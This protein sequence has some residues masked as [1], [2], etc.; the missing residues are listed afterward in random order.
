MLCDGVPDCGDWSDE[1]VCELCREQQW[2]CP[3][4]MENGAR[5][6]QCIEQEDR[7]DGPTS[8]S[9]G[10]DERHCVALASQGELVLAGD[11]TPSPG[12]RTIVFLAARPEIQWYG[13]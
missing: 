6:P 4:A 8:C 7:C 5:Q 13:Q 12:S 2:L 1:T 9:W 10:E 3:L 11:G